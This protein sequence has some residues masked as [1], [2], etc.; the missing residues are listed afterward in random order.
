MLYRQPG[1]LADD[2]EW[3][4]WREGESD[5]APRRYEY[6]DE[7]DAEEAWRRRNHRITIDCL[8]SQLVEDRKYAEIMKSIG[9]YRKPELK[10]WR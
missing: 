4:I 10:P 6:V 2:I 5:D 9:K 8:V 3:R 7:R 1:L